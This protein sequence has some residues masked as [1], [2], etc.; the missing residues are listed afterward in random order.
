MDA[1]VPGAVLR[2]SVKDGDRVSEGQEIIVLEAMKMETPVS[3]PA[4]GTIH[5]LVKQGDQVQTGH[6]LAEIK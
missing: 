6:P 2:L 3:A 4:S 1:P 5:F